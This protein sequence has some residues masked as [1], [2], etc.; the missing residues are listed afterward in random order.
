MP[1]T[2]SS[3]NGALLL[4]RQLPRIAGTLTFVLFILILGQ[5]LGA[6]LLPLAAGR[7][8]AAL[9][10]VEAA[11]FAG[12]ALLAASLVLDV[13]LDP[14][15][16][17]VTA[18]LGTAVDA[19]TA[20]RT[21][22]GALR[23]RGIAH[24]DDPKVADAIEQARAIG[25]GSFPPREAVAALSGL[26]PLRLSGIAAAVLLGWAGA[27]WMPLVLGAAWMLTGHWQELE[28]RRSV[29]AHSGEVAQLRQAAYLRDLALTPAAAKEV[30]LFGLHSWLVAGFTRSWWAGMTELRRTSINKGKHSAAIL[31]LL[32][33]HAAVIGPLAFWAAAGELSPERLAVALQ[34]MLGLFALGFAGDL[35]W[36]LHTA[37]AAIP[38]ARTVGALT[39]DIPA[40]ALPRPVDS[41]PRR[42]IRFERVS[43]R[44]PGESRPV[45]DELDLVLPAGSSLA[46][47]GDNGAGKSTIAKLLAGLY[48]PDGGRILI[49]GHDLADYDLTEWRRRLAVV[50]QDF[51][52]YPLPV[53]DNIGFGAVETPVREAELI[54]AARLGG[55]LGIEAELPKGW[56]TPLSGEF[57]EGAD[58]SGGQWQRLA[59][60]RALYAVRHGAGVLVLDE[61]TAQLDVRAEH[62][63]YARFLEI[64]QDITTILVSHRFATVRLADRIAVLRDGRVSEYGTHAELLAADG[65]YARLFRVQSAPFAAAEGNGHA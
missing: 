53:R 10:G 33:G 52:R 29:S 9:T 4:L 51:V 40:P 36:T 35:Q 3:P 19:A 46:I 5:V 59:L 25:V 63:L 47:V 1:A 54:T 38:A 49:D 12:L 16:S 42:E 11:I 7:L 20:Q 65:R 27:W 24:L 32:L 15:R 61:P 55:F 21:I 44:Y 26:I 48:R 62:D 57:A 39:D 14:I 2:T 31:L 50:F 22:E 37:S 64:T 45:L 6:V 58:L 13:V 17:M 56:D 8:V 43:F 30:R 28:I 60:S 18:R 23:P 41:L 34:A